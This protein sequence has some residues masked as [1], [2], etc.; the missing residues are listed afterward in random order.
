[1]GKSILACMLLILSYQGLLIA[2]NKRCLNYPERQR[3]IYSLKGHSKLAVE[4]NDVSK[5]KLASRKTTYRV[6]EMINIDLAILNT[7]SFPVFFRN[8]KSN[9][10]TLQV[11]YENEREARVYFQLYLEGLVPQSFSL[12]QPNGM[13]IESY[14]ILAGCNV[15]GL[16]EYETTREKIVKAL[17]LNAGIDD[18]P[19]FENNIFVNW[20]D[21]CIR[22]VRPGAYTFTAEFQHDDT[23][24]NSPCDPKAKT[25]VGSI[26]SSPLTITIIQ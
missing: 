20:G 14:Q 16:S 26:R 19:F 3:E 6:G 23:V 5:I 2:Q 10:L 12:A 7:A 25:A 8:L 4:Y 11:R 17:P 1:M 13:L 22:A 24:V 9:A 21:A 15:E 18:R